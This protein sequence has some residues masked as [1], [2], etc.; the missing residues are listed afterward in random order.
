MYF[1]WD[2]S[3]SGLAKLTTFKDYYIYDARNYKIRIEFPT[4]WAY[5]YL[6]YAST[7]PIVLYNYPCR[8]TGT[9]TESSN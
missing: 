1:T 8:V 4:T 6:G 7:D 5:Q 3:D 2:S 9:F